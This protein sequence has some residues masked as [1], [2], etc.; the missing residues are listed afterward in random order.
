MAY[1]SFIIDNTKTDSI[2]LA[3]GGTIYIPAGSITDSAGNPLTTPVTLKYREFHDAASIL[4]SG[5]PMKYPDDATGKNREFESAGMF[6]LRAASEGKPV[7]INKEKPITVK[8]ASYK[9][10]KEFN[11]FY[12]NEKTGSWMFCGDAPPV[13]NPKKKTL[14]DKLAKLTNSLKTPFDKDCI[15]L[16][17][18]SMLDVYF[19][20]DYNKIYPYR[21]KTKTEFPER[22]K[23]YGIKTTNIIVHDWITYKGMSFHPGMLAWKN[24]EK[25]NI[26][27][28]T[29]GKA[30]KLIQQADKSYLLTVSDKKEKKEFSMKVKP[31][32]LLKNL[33]AFAPEHWNTSREELTRQIAE[34]EATLQFTADV[35]RTFE[36]NNFGVHNW[37]CF[38]N[39]EERFTVNAAFEFDSKHSALNE[40]DMVY[41]ISKQTNSVVKLYKHQWNNMILFKDTSACLAAILPGNT[42]ALYSREKYAKL[43]V[44]EFRRQQNMAVNFKMVNS[45]KVSS[46]EDIKKVLGI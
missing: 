24:L 32:M 16:D 26:P 10:G 11:F 37:D 23:Q 31:L 28:W 25:K 43:D 20:E 34:V 38:K 39:Q 45:Q 14:R 12:M 19:R 33:F 35:F 9:E 44:E 21:N 15:A 1:D 30:G 40:T 7:F 8:M 5:I 17:N 13:S 18:L 46:G 29:K 42:I 36:V 27:E 2:T 3:N 22:I 41:F 6:D 4:I